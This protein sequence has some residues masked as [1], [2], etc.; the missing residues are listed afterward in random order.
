MV[1]ADPTLEA[2]EEL[3]RAGRQNMANWLVL[4]ERVDRVRELR[5]QGVTYRDMNVGQ[6]MSVI[7]A[8]SDNQDRLTVAAAKFRRA[9]AHE[10]HSEGLTPAAIARLYGVSRQRVASLLAGT[11]TAAARAA[12]LDSV[13]LDVTQ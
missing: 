9:M 1:D 11:E 13:E 8:I 12:E 5:A 7:E 2:L 6:G 4:M 3:V 10:L